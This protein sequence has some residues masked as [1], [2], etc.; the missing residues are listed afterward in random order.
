MYVMMIYVQ[1]LIYKLPSVFKKSYKFFLVLQSGRILVGKLRSVEDSQIN[2]KQKLAML[3]VKI[4][5]VQQS[6]E[7]M[8]SCTV[9][10]HAN[11]QKVAKKYIPV[12]G[13]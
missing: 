12:L 9:K 13:K 11:N 8:Y 7:G 6:D 1:L 2:S 3:T 5:K 4:K 10:D